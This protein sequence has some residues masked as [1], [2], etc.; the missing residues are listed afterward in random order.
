MQKLATLNLKKEFTMDFSRYSDWIRT[1][2]EMNC[3]LVKKVGGLI[4]ET[5]FGVQLIAQG[6]ITVQRFTLTRL[7]IFVSWE[8]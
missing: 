5:Q 7:E 1:L 3:H 4:S 8:V 2:F 6:S